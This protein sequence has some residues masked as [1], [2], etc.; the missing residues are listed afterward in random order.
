VYLS[1]NEALRHSQ[2]VGYVCDGEESVV[3]HH[4]TLRDRDRSGR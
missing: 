3:D 4:L 1:F 2:V